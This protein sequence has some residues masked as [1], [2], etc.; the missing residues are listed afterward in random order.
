MTSIRYWSQDDQRHARTI[1]FSTVAK[2][3]EML[4]FYQGAGIRC[5]LAK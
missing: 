3:L 4:A 2:A 1:S 5:E